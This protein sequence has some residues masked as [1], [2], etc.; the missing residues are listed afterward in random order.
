MEPW[1]PGL[2][3]SLSLPT[4]GDSTLGCLLPKWQSPTIAKLAASGN[5]MDSMLVNP[6]RQ[7]PGL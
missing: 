4:L 3:L 6:D 7:H 1:N 5:W 2:V